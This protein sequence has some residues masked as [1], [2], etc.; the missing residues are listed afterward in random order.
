MPECD[1][2]LVGR[3]LPHEANRLSPPWERPASRSGWRGEGA[4]VSFLR[5]Q[6][7]R[8]KQLDT[9]LGVKGFLGKMEFRSVHGEAPK[10]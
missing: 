4:P 5:K 2:S 7:S 6:E 10:E 8:K 1:I 9:V 3:F